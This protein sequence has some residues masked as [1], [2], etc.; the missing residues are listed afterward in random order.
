MLDL[1]KYIIRQ[2]DLHERVA[3]E[4]VTKFNDLPQSFLSDN[5]LESIYFINRKI[6]NIFFNNTIKLVYSQVRKEVVQQFKER[7]RKQRHTRSE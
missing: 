4:N 3:A 6:C 5:R 7:Q 1:C 2:S